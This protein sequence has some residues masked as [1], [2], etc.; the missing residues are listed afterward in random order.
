MRK[1]VYICDRCH[2]EYDRKDMT[3]ATNRTILASIRDFSI[4]VYGCD[5]PEMQRTIQGA[6]EL[7]PE[8]A[9]RFVDWLQEY[10]IKMSEV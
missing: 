5:K 1:T 10:K 7:C 2:K 8:C 3:K 9:G 6:Y 4:N